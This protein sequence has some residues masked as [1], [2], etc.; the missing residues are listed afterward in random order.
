MKSE[1]TLL[2]RIEIRGEVLKGRPVIKGTR[3]SVEIILKSL[4]QGMS[5]DEIS[6]GY[7]ISDEDVRAAILYAQKIIESETVIV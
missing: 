3:V 5:P 4:A 1:G 2:D 6:K 7:D